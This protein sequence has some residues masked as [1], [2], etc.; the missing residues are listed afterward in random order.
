MEGNVPSI[1]VIV[2]I[3][4][5]ERYIERCICSLRKQT[6]TNLEI[7]L[8]NDAST[9]RSYA[10]CTKQVAHDSRIKLFNLHANVGVDRARFEGLSISTGR[11]VMFVDGDDYL[12]SCAAE[13]LYRMMV[14]TDADVVAGSYNRVYDSLG[15][16]KRRSSDDLRMQED[17]VELTQPEL[18]ERYY[19]SFFGIT[20]LRVQLWGKL[21]RRDLFVRAGI[22][23]TG[24]KMGEDLAVHLSLFPFVRKYVVMKDVAYCYRYGGMS[25]VYNP[26]FYPEHKKLYALKMSMIERYGYDVVWLSTQI[27]MCHIFCFQWTQQFRYGMR[28]DAIKK[29]LEE[30][31]ATGFLKEITEGVHN[32]Q[33]PFSFLKSED[34]EG[35][36]H[37]CEQEGRKRRGLRLAYRLI[38]PLLRII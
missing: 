10:L 33:P 21:Y 35:L 1:S 37:W 26:Y 22:K 17:W 13:R 3:Y 20:L 30:E 28:K 24:L 34:V 15:W 19:R 7:I 29:A 18:F 11:Y 23:P 8:V 38:A 14:L 2:T 9:D 16:I 32:E 27:E 25:T 31:I 4:N 36:L 12:P 6:F 5:V